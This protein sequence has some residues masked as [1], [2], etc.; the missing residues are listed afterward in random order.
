MIRVLICGSWIRLIAFSSRVVIERSACPISSVWR[1]GRDSMHLTNGRMAELPH[2]IY[3]ATNLQG[4]GLAPHEVHQRKA[5]KY[6]TLAARNV[7]R[8]KA[9]ILALSPLGK[10]SVPSLRTNLKHSMRSHIHGSNRNRIV[11]HV[12]PSDSRNSAR[13]S[14]RLLISMQY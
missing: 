8:C 14:W 5:G 1:F 3:T 2:T 9:P 11:L 10:F 12:M 7:S 13:R 4:W 6:F